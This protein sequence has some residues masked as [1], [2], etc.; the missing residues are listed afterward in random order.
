MPR[1]AVLFAAADVD[2]PGAF[3]VR[4]GETPVLP[5]TSYDA[6]GIARPEAEARTVAAV[7]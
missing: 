1:L 2:V 3:V 6:D 5:A 7:R 4:L